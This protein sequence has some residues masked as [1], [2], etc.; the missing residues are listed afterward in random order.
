MASTTPAE[1]KA[2]QN[3]DPNARKD[4]GR[5]GGGREIPEQH[6]SHHQRREGVVGEEAKPELTK[7]EVLQSFLA[8]VSRA[9]S[10]ALGFYF[11][12]PV[13]LFRPAIIE[14]FGIAA[15]YLAGSN[16]VWHQF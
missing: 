6:H 4:S 9:A 2:P 10:R 1:K 8:S 11:K 15:A 7:E 3:E 14:V 16:P 5:S 13:K 12:N